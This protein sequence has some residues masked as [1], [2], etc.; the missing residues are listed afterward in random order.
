MWA[1]RELMCCRSPDVL[2]EGWKPGWGT[3]TCLPPVLP[4]SCTL[5]VLA[6]SIGVSL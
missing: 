5:V 4:A 1:V 3:A 6:L 2:E